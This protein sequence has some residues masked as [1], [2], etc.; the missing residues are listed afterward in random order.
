MSYENLNIYRAAFQLTV[1]V[2]QCVRK[3][4]KCDKTFGTEL[5]IM[6]TELLYKIATLN[7]CEDREKAEFCRMLRSKLNPLQIKIAIS[8]EINV[9]DS[10]K[11]WF[12]TSELLK[13]VV[14]Q[15]EKLLRYFDNRQ[16]HGGSAPQ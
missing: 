15:N 3:F 10:Y 13:D 6:V 9:F 7:E 8:E 2:E 12:R 1:Q 16:I 4:H 14:D 11:S 5:R